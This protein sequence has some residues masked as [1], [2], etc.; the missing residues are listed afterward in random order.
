MVVSTLL[1]PSICQAVNLGNLLEKSLADSTGSQLEE[2]FGGLSSSPEFAATVKN[3]AARLGQTEM[4]KGKPFDVRIL[5]S[6]EVNALS[7]PAERVYVLEGLLQSFPVLDDVAFV[8][9]HEY[10]H[11]LKKHGMKQMG[12]TAGLGLVLGKENTVKQIVK[13]LLVNGRSREDEKEAD[14]EAI[15]LMSQA[16]YNLSGALGAMRRLETLGKKNPTIVDKLFATHPPTK[17]RAE[18]IKSAMLVSELGTDYRSN[19]NQ[20]QGQANEVP[21]KVEII[22]DDGTRGK[23]QTDYSVGPNG[24]FCLIVPYLCQF[25][26]K[27]PSNMNCGPTAVEMA[28]GFAQGREPTHDNVVALNKAMGRKDP[29]KGAMTG[30]Q[31]LTLACTKT[32]GLPVKYVKMTLEQALEE[33]KQGAPVVVGV[34]YKELKNREDQKYTSGHFVV[35]IGF[36]EKY[37]YTNDPDSL[38]KTGAMVKYDRGQFS[39]AMKGLGSGCLVGFAKQNVAS[40]AK[41]TPGKYDAYRT[42]MTLE[43]GPIHLGDD[44]KD[45]KMVWFKEFELVEQDL[46]GATN[47]TV[48][49]ELKAMPK[50]DP[51]ISFNRHE[52]A[53]AV[54]TS[55]KWQKFQFSFKPDLLY[56]GKNLIDLETIIVNLT[57]TYDDCDFRNL[58]LTL[59]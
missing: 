8:M 1:F 41:T 44:T 15:N 26:T 50:K 42:K 52:V 12:L 9:S 6:D 28:A 34:S 14:R 57:S 31:E 23:A 30:Y 51:I 46:S 38:K 53:V 7:L 27:S 11:C 5:A 48:S 59:D 55:D 25:W 19:P 54:A 17:D 16:G 35:M 22:V 2:E 18:V 39:K 3:I 40:P 10:V 58:E 56:V 32:F 47:A 24:E 43:K 36:D 4:V 21:K 33:V 49:L 13:V 45:A 20:A 37:I 29:L